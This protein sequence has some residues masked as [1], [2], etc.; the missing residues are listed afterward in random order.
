ML[1][2]NF[3]TA[4]FEVEEYNAQPISISYKFKETDKVVTK[5]LFKVATS[6][7]SVKSITFDNKTGGLDL[8]VHYS[9]D[10]QLMS[11]LPTQIAQY[12]I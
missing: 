6:F 3:Q 5:D 4:T 7:P 12:D 8:M 9:Q 2:A 10:A 1:S 11:G